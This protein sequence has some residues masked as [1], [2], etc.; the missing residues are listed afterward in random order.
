MKCPECKETLEEIFGDSRIGECP[1][2]HGRW[3]DKDYAEVID[4][5]R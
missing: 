1:N 3:T 2:G 5:T 4:S